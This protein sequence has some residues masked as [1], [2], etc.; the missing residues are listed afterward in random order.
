MLAAYVAIAWIYGGIYAWDRWPAPD[1]VMDAALEGLLWPY[2]LWVLIFLGA[3]P[4]SR[5][6]ASPTW[7]P[8]TPL[9]GASSF[10]PAGLTAHIQYGAGS[11][12]ATPVDG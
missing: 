1:I 2:R 7:G 4:K 6:H 5:G 11:T 8:P 9:R 10:E 12:V 3:P